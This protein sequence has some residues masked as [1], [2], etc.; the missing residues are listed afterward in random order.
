MTGNTYS[1]TQEE[2]LELSSPK[3]L[4]SPFSLLITERELLYVVR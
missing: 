3:R 4:S 2:Y 1:F